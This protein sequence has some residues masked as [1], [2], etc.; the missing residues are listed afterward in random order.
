MSNNTKAQNRHLG[1]AALLLI[2]G[3]LLGYGIATL[4]AT[5]TRPCNTLSQG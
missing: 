3:T 2:A 4:T 5:K 1:I